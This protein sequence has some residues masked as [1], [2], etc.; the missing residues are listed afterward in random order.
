MLFMSAFDDLKKKI[1]EDPTSFV[2]VLGAGASIP[3][4]LPSWEG[5]RNILYDTLPDIF[6]DPTDL[7]NAQKNIDESH[8]LWESFS[9]LK[10]YLGNG[11]YEKTILQALDCGGRPIPKLYQQIWKLN[12]SGIINF[13]IDKFAVDAYSAV[14]GQSVD[15]A[16]G[17]EPHKFRNFCGSSD[18]FVFH[19]HGILSDTSSWVFTVN[20][21][22]NLYKNKDFKNI[23]TA[24]F[25]T[26]NLLIIGFNA[27]EWSF[28]QLI[29]EC[30]ITQKLNGVHNYYFCPDATSNIQRTLGELGLSVIPYEPHDK[31][32]SQLNESLETIQNFKSVDTALPTIYAGKIYSESDIPSEEECYK[33]TV[34]QLRDILNGVIAG[35]IPANT[36]PTNTQLHNLES[37]YNTYITQ[38]HRAWLV[39]PKKPSTAKVYNYT[40]TRFI[41]NGAFGSV[42][43]AEDDDKKRYA[44][45]VLSPEVKDNCILS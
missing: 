39:N 1:V 17:N 9:R 32:H 2:V 43:E 4:G 6:E 3:A 24:I 33:Y 21:R 38:L 45:K 22:R 23:I 44:L 27:K 26:K 31:D 29:K 14:Y 13:N 20:R 35:I 5:L 36:I 10:R 19:P 16:T 25:N 15:V 7:A 8:N 40:T 37:F 30:G 12:V 18:K 34:D 41:G 42:F 11:I 28:Q